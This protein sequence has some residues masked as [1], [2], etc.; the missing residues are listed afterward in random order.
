VRIA[1]II[2]RLVARGPIKV[3]QALVNCLAGSDGI[4][5][6]VFYLDKEVDE[7]VTMR[8]PVHRYNSSTFR[9]EDFDIVHTNGIRPD[10][11]AFLNRR[12]IKK[13][14]ST[15]HNFVFDDLGYSYN[16]IISWIF[17][18]IWLLLWS[19]ADKLVCVSDS[20]KSYYEKWLP[21]EKLLS[22][23]NGIPE[24]DSMKIPDN[25]LISEISGYR[26]KGLKVIGTVSILTKGK[27]LEQVIKLLEIE[28][29]LSL[30]IIGNGEEEDSLIRLAKRTGVDDRVYFSGFRDSPSIYLKYFD[31]FLMPSRTEGFGLVLVEAVQQKVPIV[32]S[33]IEVFNE[34]FNED[35]ITFFNLNDF[36]TLP[37]AIHVATET[38]QIKTEAAY[39]RYLNNYT[40]RTMA[41]NYYDL[42]QSV[43]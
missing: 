41:K 31:L 12:K 3:M 37:E 18:N 42:Y 17:G 28:P 38:R 30:V 1:I 24:P 13:H 40:D 29:D 39:I 27:G 34:L 8:V 21:D 6:E 26:K 32:C 19:R 35:E 33:D 20:L 5:I 7:S 22:I 10:L 36:T 15:I 9:F 25:D 23:H 4:N 11:K 14:I 2:P 43:L 16:S